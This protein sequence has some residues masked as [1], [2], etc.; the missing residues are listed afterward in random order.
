MILT[1]TQNS[2]SDEAVIII[3]PNRN[4]SWR[5]SK[6]LFLFFAFFC[7]LVAVCFWSI[8]AWLVAPFAGL[9]ILLIGI[10]IYCQSCFAHS[11]QTISIDNNHLR[12]SSSL[13]N[14]SEKCFHKAWLKVIQNHD[15]RGWYPSRL[16]IGAHGEYIEVGKTLIEEEREVLARNLRSI[17]EGTLPV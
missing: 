2:D 8:G 16:L 13:S 1:E 6:W 17:T 5:Q 10:A 3:I 4:L 9:E 11:R 12:V 7:A 15:P 14:Q